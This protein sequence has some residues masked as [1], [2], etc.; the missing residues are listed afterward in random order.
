MLFT[1][2]IVLETFKAFR[3]SQHLDEGANRTYRWVFMLPEE[4]AEMES[5]I[6]YVCRLS[7]AIKRTAEN[8][9]FSYLCIR[10]CFTDSEEDAEI[11]R[12]IIVID[13]KKDVSWLLNIMQ[14]RFLQINEWEAQMKQALIDTCDYQSL[15]ALCEPVLNNFVSVLDS[16]Y[17]LLAYTK[18]ITSSDPINISLLEKGYHTEE[19]M[20][21]FKDVR[22]FGVYEHEHGVIIG[23]AGTLS[24]FEVVSK[25]C[26]YGGQPLLHVVMVCSKTPLSPA[27][28]ELFEVLMK[29]VEACFYREQR[30]N[31]SQE[32]TSLLSD[33]LYEGIENP[34]A[35]GERAKTSDLPFSGNFDAYRIVFKDNA[36]VLVGRFTQELMS[37]LP[38]SRIVAHDYEISVLN[39]YT[40]SE[41]QKHTRANLRILE[42]LFE[43][44]GVLCGVS[45]AFASLPEFKNACVQ[46]TRAQA[47]GIQLRNLGNFWNFDAEVLE[48]VLRGGERDVF[49]Y[50]DIYIFLMLHRAQAGNFDVFNNT[51]Y[52][53]ILKKLRDYDAENDTR[54]VQVLYVYL[55]CERRATSAGR[56]L[57]MHRNNVLYHVSRIEEIL[58]VSLDDYWVRLKLQLAF[59]FLELQESNC[60]F[61]LPASDRATEL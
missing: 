49:F 11:L 42:P 26:R 36:S 57:H 10:D 59:H 17:K 5:D 53:N 29:Y 58:G 39:I 18:N 44:Y 25:W 4:S 20:Q 45:E 48:S 13:E 31:P 54:L 40:S 14:S 34:F 43:R 3:G 24:Q 52:N 23:A 51:I 41:V 12:G 37:Y 50:N 38:K 33:M 60:V 55:L 1:K 61:T 21:K 15:I 27:M 35:I 7:E 6:L 47:L 32:Y 2:N 30:Q 46:A 16:S 22:R 8:P 9:G 56:L 19:T 28:I